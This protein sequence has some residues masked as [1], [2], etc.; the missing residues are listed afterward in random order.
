MAFRVSRPIFPCSDISVPFNVHKSLAFPL[1]YAGVRVCSED[2]AL[3]RYETEAYEVVKCGVKGR[4]N[5]LHGDTYCFVDTS[6]S[7]YRNSE[8]SL[9][10]F[11]LF[12]ARRSTKLEMSHGEWYF[13]GPSK[14]DMATLRLHARGIL[15]STTIRIMIPVCIKHR[16]TTVERQLGYAPT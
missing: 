10:G 7:T 15:A 5:L 13:R 4:E 14:G 11:G 8:T 16:E 12:A 9:V 2:E 6:I 3:K 1:A